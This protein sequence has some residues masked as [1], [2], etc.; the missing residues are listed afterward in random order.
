LSSVATSMVLSARCDAATSPRYGYEV[1][2]T[3]SGLKI[4]LSPVPEQA[5]VEWRVSGGLT[6]YE[7]ALDL[8]AARVAAI[9]GGAEPELVWLR[10]PELGAEREDKIA[11]IGI[12]VQRWVTLHGLALNIDCD[13]AH[14]SGIVPCGVSDP[15]YGV[16]SLADL[17][18][19][20]TMADVDGALRREFEG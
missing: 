5:P 7:E 2:N 17:G 10:R 6:G 1:V 14:F 11:A 16:T 18:Q 8:M 9:A 3:R 13:L 19:P 4:G 20:V 15:R 12:R